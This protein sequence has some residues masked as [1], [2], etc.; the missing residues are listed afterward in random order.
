LLNLPD[1][2]LSF[3]EEKSFE[4]FKDKNAFTGNSAILNVTQ[5]FRNFC[6]EN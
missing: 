2:I 3:Q 4:L 1:V 5:K 6:S